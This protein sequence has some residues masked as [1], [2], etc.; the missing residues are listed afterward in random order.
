V[1]DR[2]RIDDWRHAELM[3]L[4]ANIN[5]NSKVQ[6]TPFSATDFLSWWEKSAAAAGNAPVDLGDAKA[7]SDLIKAAMFGR[8]SEKGK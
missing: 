1:P 6:S 3:S 4:T 8:I 7:Q 2:E 5:R